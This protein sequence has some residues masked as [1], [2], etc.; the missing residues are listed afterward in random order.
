MRR[1]RRRCSGCGPT[2][3]PGRNATDRQV[4]AVLES[5]VEH[6]VH[7]TDL[8]T[9][10]DL[11]DGDAGSGPAV[12]A[13]RRRCGVGGQDHRAGRAGQP[14]A[15][16]A[17]P[18][19]Q[20]QV[21][22]TV[23][24]FMRAAPQVGVL[25]NTWVTQ[26]RTGMMGQLDENRLVRNSH[27]ERSRDSP[28]FQASAWFAFF[29]PKDVPKP[30]LNR[31]SDALDAALDDEGVRKRLVDLGGDIPDKSKRGQQPLRRW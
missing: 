26:T 19:L 13:A 31:L 10:L 22:V 16:G 21:S 25:L 1:G 27:V 4:G 2:S 11:A 8:V 14:P 30:I 6:I 12:V 3:R 28:N 9:N 18:A 7:G 15:G 24:E 29:A 23:W 20:T 17:F 5:V